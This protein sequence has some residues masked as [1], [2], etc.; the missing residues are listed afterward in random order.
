MARKIHHSAG[1]YGG[2]DASRER[3]AVLLSGAYDLHIE[4]SCASARASDPATCRMDPP[5]EGGAA[6]GTVILQGVCLTEVHTGRN[7]ACPELEAATGLFLNGRRS[8]P[9]RRG[10]VDDRRTSLGVV[11]VEE[12]SDR[13][14]HVVTEFGPPSLSG[15]TSGPD[16]PQRDGLSR[17]GRPGGE[18]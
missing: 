8:L 18:V 11:N 15:E 10:A 16:R 13:G 3:R 14:A 2:A 7:S 6:H 5:A 4:R 17:G 1:H 9:P 12:P